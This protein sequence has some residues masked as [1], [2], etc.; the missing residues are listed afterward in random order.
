MQDDQLNILS[1]DINDDMGIVVELER[2]FRVSY[3]FH[4]RYVRFEHVFQDVFCISGSSHPENFHP[5]ILCFHLL[6]QVLEHLDRVLNRVA[7]RE[8]IG[9]AKDV[10]A[11]VQ[12]DSLRGGG[13]TVDSNKSRHSSAALEVGR[14]EFLATVGLLER[15]QLGLIFDETTRTRL[16]L[17]FLPT[18]LDVMN[19]LIV[20]AIAAHA[21]IFSF[22]EFD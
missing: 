4:Q 9:L 17:L 15:F 7:I 19:Q 13:T 21:V 8:L 3:G 22:A 20:A 11:L 18:V 2:R 12:Q 6:A 10:A 5:R 14:H 1:S 16:G